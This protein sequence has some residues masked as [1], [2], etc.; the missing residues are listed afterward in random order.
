M[1]L[2]ST[3]ANRADKPKIKD[4]LCTVFEEEESVI[5]CGLDTVLVPVF[6]GSKKQCELFISKTCVNELPAN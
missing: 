4:L 2:K 1:K 3:F 5:G 6:K